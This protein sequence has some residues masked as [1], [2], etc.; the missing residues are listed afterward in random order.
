MNET[1]EY[2][3]LARKE[4]F[5]LIKG[6]PKAILECGCAF[7]ELGKH[8]K[9]SWDCTI[10]GLELN[11]KAGEYL[12]KVYDKFYITDLE[13]FDVAALNAQFDCIIYADI[14][15]H[16]RDPKKILKKHLESLQ[17]GGQVIISIPNIRNLKIIADL[18]V[19]GEWT[20]GD[21]GIL[22]STHYKFF[23]LKTLKQMLQECGL[24]VE[25]VSN[26][27]DEFTG[28]KKMVSLIPYLIVPELKVCQWLIR[29]RKL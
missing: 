29:A 28:L 27:K 8:I 14:L 12:E 7:G 3:S 24:E 13:A 20:Y 6:Q 26:N 25:I 17:K 2:Y 16:L 18:L 11:P 19:K 1:V 9:K 22:D 4:V 5:H 21:S 10:T 23:T 15:E